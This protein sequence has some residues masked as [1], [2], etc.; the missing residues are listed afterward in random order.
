M[1][2]LRPFFLLLL[3]ISA[4]ELL[5]SVPDVSPYNPKPSE[6]DLVLPMPSGAEM[7]FRQVQVPGDSFWGDSDRLIQVG[8][9]EGGI[10]EGLQRVQ[11]SG[12]F[13]DE[14]GNSWLY[15]LGKYEVTIGQYIALMGFDAL[16]KASGD[17]AQIAELKKL[18]G[19]R[20]QK[21]LA[22]PL[23]FMRWSDIQAL[24]RAYN[25]WLFDQGHNDRLREMPKI[26]EVPGYLRL[27]TEIEWEY[28]ARGGIEAMRDG[29]FRNK[30]P[31]ADAQMV[32]YAWF[33]DN[34]KHKV[35]PVGLR[36]PNELG[37]HDM[38]GN[39]QELTSDLF[40]PEIWQGKP[41][42][43][44]ARGGSVATPKADMRSSH[45]EEVETYR[46]VED[47][48]Q[49]REW[50]SYNTGFRLALGSNVVLNPANRRRL[51]Q[52]YQGYRSSIRSTMP[53]G[54]TLENQVGQAQI[55]LRDAG[56]ELE[57]LA[58]EN[59]DLQRQLSI[60]QQEIDKAAEKLDWAQ[61]TSAHSTAEATL[62]R[63][64]DLARDIFKLESL[65]GQREKVARLA[66]KSTRYQDLQNTVEQEIQHRQNYAD[67]LYIEYEKDIRR[68]GE[69][70]DVYIQQAFDKLEERNLTPRAKLALG[71]MA[72]HLGDYRDNRRITAGRWLPAFRKHFKSLPD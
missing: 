19:K 71:L 6:G 60:V 15:Y 27:P 48:K 49:M 31:F 41:G 12:S 10:F 33:L 20:L 53:V 64:T 1:S 69:Y 29:S 46:W 43:R 2:N 52:D 30:L 24:I 35:R 4:G 58:N 39:A 50:R 61:R 45:R 22:K 63:A 28:A 47:D 5:A 23:V 37:L 36:L 25:L 54:I 59:K 9:G 67:K 38:L 34:A 72:I 8:D 68:L 70:A 62:R 32:K 13:P 17:T 21:A 66:Q 65:N 57:K 14:S 40:R 16:Q 51:E 11:V 42:G 18:Q 26:D 3:F 56:G 7:V 55:Q 44:S